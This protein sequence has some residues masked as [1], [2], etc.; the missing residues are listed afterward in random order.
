MVDRQLFRQIKGM[1]REQIENL[2]R[3]TY[4]MGA[5]SVQLEVDTDQLRKDIGSVK[6]I[7]EARL[8][9]I[10]SIIERDLKLVDKDEA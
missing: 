8:N 4:Q 5:D 3:T 1:N 10:M 9:E 7:G 6:G 2:L